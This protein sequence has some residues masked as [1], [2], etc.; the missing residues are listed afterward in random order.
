M[1]VTR[2]GN[3]LTIEIRTCILQITNLS[4]EKDI[5][6]FA[7]GRLDNLFNVCCIIDLPDLRLTGAFNDFYYS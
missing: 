6:T 3:E 7:M 4:E 2:G 5:P 1:H